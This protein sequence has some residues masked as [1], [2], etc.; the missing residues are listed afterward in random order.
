M[1]RSFSDLE[2]AY[3]CLV[4]SFRSHATFLP[5]KVSVLIFQMRKQKCDGEKYLAPGCTFWLF[6]ALSPLLCFSTSSAFGLN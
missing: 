4:L 3:I 2:S 6:L 5:A 1:S